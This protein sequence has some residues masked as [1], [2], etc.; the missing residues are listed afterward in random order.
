MS[1]L[2]SAGKWNSLILFSITVRSF[3]LIL[4][5]TLCASASAGPLPA[6]ATKWQPGHYIRYTVQ[7]NILDNPVARAE[8]LIKIER[9]VKQRSNFKGIL[10]Q[11]RWR[12]FEPQENVYDFSFINEVLN[13]VG[14]HDKYLLVRIM[15][16]DF[17]NKPAGVFPKY[18]LDKNWYWCKASGAPC[19]A[20]N[21]EP[22]V[23]DRFIALLK[24][25][26]AKF[27]THARLVGIVNAETAA[28][29]A[30]RDRKTSGY[31]TVAYT[32]QIVR[33]NRE[34][35]AAAKHTILFQ[36]FNSLK[37][38]EP[39]E[40]FDQIIDAVV[41]AGD[42]LTHPDTFPCDNTGYTNCEKDNFA[43]YY[44]ERAYG[45][46][47]TK[48][49]PVMAQIQ[50]ANKFDWTPE[51]LHSTAYKYLG[52]NFIVWNAWLNTFDSELV[53]LLEKNRYQSVTV[54]PSNIAYCYGG[55]S[56]GSAT[57]EAVAP[58]PPLGFNVD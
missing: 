30:G 19:L 56:S 9:L 37:S 20:R 1:I 21:W 22:E 51:E 38:N 44:Y 50:R 13:I 36:S 43:P 54:C 52:A 29:G 49:I 10:L 23:M 27:D 2:P 31:S 28:G 8:E 47:G 17:S 58:N 33:F 57:S 34:L 26:A 40:Y 18:I 32:N 6:N 24:S 46:K 7:S 45:S 4:I 16:R 41:G 3:S 11:T 5:F 35:S 53:P 48:K 12:Y 15:D 55:D 42:G 14:A 39:N 25:F